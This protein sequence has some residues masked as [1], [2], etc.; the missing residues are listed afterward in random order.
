[1]NTELSAESNLCSIIETL[2]A[3]KSGSGWAARCPAHEDR[4]PSLSITFRDGKILL[5]CHAGCSQD[6]VIAAL[7]DRGLWREG[8]QTARVITATYAYT[9]EAGE[10]ALPDRA[11]GTESL[12]TATPRWH[13]RVDLAKR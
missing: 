4:N 7:R 2:H 9:D 13:R 12:S 10:T 1:M 3:R 6:D 5:H 8:E 11:P